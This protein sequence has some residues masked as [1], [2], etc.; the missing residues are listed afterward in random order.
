MEEG[1]Q[2]EL[3]L[4]PS[5]HSSCSYSQMRSRPPDFSSLR[6]RSSSATVSDH[7]Q[8]GGPSL[9]LQLSIS[10]SPIQAPSNCVLTGSICDFS[11]GNKA[12]T[13]CVEAMKWQA[14]EQI[15]LATIEKAYAERVRELTRKEIELAQSEFARARHMWQRAREEVEK[16]ERMKERATRQIDSTC[17]EITC[18]SCRQRFKP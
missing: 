2:K 15:R 7:Q 14:A 17:M 9:D 18:Q 1:G 10:L 13:S 6:Y 4:L 16:A 5:Q 11:D 8:F 3:Q 12:D